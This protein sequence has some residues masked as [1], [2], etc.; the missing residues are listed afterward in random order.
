[1]TCVVASSPAV[2]EDPEEG[3]AVKAGWNLGETPFSDA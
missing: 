3:R 2:E 1:M